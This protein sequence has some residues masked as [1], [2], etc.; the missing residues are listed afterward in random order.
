MIIITQGN[1]DLTRTCEMYTMGSL[2]QIVL[3]K[4]GLDVSFGNNKKAEAALQL[5]K[6]EIKRQASS[7]RCEIVIDIDE[8]NGRVEKG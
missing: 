1:I 4:D 8:I 2:V 5:I 7:C 6:Q 3:D